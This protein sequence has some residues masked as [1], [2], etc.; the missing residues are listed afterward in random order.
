LIATEHL[1]TTGAPAHIQ[2]SPDRTVL[3]ADGQDTVVIPVSILD[4]KSR[5]VPYATNRVAFQLTG[6][7]CI[8]G[9]GNGNPSDHD[10][11]RANQRNAFHGR[12]IVIIQA[13][14]KPETLQLTATSPGLKGASAT[15]KVK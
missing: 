3:H 7:G 11:D 9:V 12:C 6:G 2:L 14:A 13:G 8:L 4:G 5:V 1:E 10:P 15:L